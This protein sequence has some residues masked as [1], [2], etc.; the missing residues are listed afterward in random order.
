MNNLYRVIKRSFLPSI[1]KEELNP[2]SDLVATHNE[3]EWDVIGSDPSFTIDRGRL[4]NNP[5]WYMIELNASSDVNPSL[6]E[7]QFNYIGADIEH[8]CI[9]LQHFSGRLCKRLCYIRGNLVNIKFKPNPS[10]KSLLIN[11]FSI[12][13]VSSS[14]ATRRM[15]KKI[16]NN[17]PAYRHKSYQAISK[18]I[19][20]KSSLEKTEYID[21]LYDA[22]NGLFSTITSPVNYEDWLYNYENEHAVSG[23]DIR[24]SISSF[25][26]NPVISVVVPTYN[27]DD[28]FLRKCLDSVLSQSYPFFELCISDDASTNNQVHKTLKEYADRDSRIKLTLRDSNGHISEATNSAIGIS[29]GE[30]IAFLDHDDELTKDALFHIAEAINSNPSVRIVYSDEDKIDTDGRRSCPHMKSDWN[31]DLFL[32]QNYISHLTVINAK[33]V[34]KVG[35]LRTGVEGSQDYDLLLRCISSIDDTEIIH[36][37]KILYHW[38]IT[39]SSTAS[40]S[41]SKDY[42]SAAGLKALN[43]HLKRTRL[44]NDAMLGTLPN[45]YSVSYPIPSPEPLVSIIV[46]TRDN[47]ELLKTCIASVVKSTDYSNY[48]ILILDNQSNKRDTLEYLA[49]IRTNP[50][51]KVL[52]YNK[53]FNYSAINNFGVRQAKGSIVCLLNDDTEVISPDWLTTMVSH[54][55]RP[56][57]GCVGAK[58]FYTDGKIQ[59]SGVILGIG[60]VAGHAHKY[61]KQHDYGYFGRLFLT[62]NYSAVTGACLVVRKSIYEEVGGLN[63]IN[64]PISF[65]DVDFCLNVRQAGYRN[66]WTPLAELYHH[67]SVSRGFDDTLKKQQRAASEASYMKEK[68]GDGLIHDPAYNPNLT[69]LREDFSLANL[70]SR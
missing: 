26:F 58:L 12:S 4:T 33:L 11:H 36:V 14:F 59:H 8:D 19:S 51:I 22:Y 43:D 42:T 15:L 66:V 50:K 24:S 29:S 9:A 52:S 13:K 49:T 63:E 64:L 45:T 32:S 61:E 60:G 5:G 17:H 55:L 10:T 67:E 47:V 57:I 27:P 68:W 35:C 62:Q 38:R 41:E 48:E 40:S 70:E 30:F 69:L 37:P 7:L 3:D 2:N 21:K 25:K 23:E 39:E 20:R 65:N 1:E 44:G 18:E 6:S 53:A 46:P 31:P 16:R 54:S 56:E 34:K 28:N